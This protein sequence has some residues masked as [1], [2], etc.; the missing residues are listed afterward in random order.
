MTQ[1]A[2]RCLRGLGRR[3]KPLTMRKML[4][5]IGKMGAAARV[6]CCEAGAG[7]F[8]AEALTTPVFGPGSNQGNTFWAA[9]SQGSKVVLA[10]PPLIGN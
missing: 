7:S 3:T 6:F 1:R 10:S 2:M 4:D 8:C 9:F 5:R